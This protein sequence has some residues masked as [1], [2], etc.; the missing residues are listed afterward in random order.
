[1]KKTVFLGMLLSIG[2]YAQNSLYVNGNLHIAAG[3]TLHAEGGIDA[4]GASAVVNNLGTL[5]IKGGATGTDNINL[6]ASSTLNL[7]GTGTFTFLNQTHDTV[8]NLG[9][10]DNAK[11]IVPHSRTLF[12]DEVLTNN[13]TEGVTLEADQTSGAYAQLKFDSYAGT[14]TVKQEQ[15]L[16]YEGWHQIA[17]SVAGSLDQFGLINNA[18]GNANTFNTYVWNT[19]TGNWTQAGTS[20]T[21]IAAGTGY[22]TYVG[23]NGIAANNT[24]LDVVGVPFNNVAPTVANNTSNSQFNIAGSV[25]HNWNL[26]GNPFTCALDWNGITKTDVGSAFYIFNGTGSANITSGNYTAGQGSWVT[27]S[28]AS[29]PNATSTIAPLQAFWVQG[30]GSGN[31]S[32]GTL[33]ISTHG[34]MESSPVFYKTSS[35]QDW[36]TLVVMHD[37]DSIKQDQTTLTL[38]NGNGATDGFDIAWDAHKMANGGTIPSVYTFENNNAMAINAINFGPLHNQNKSINV[39]FKSIEQGA[40][41]SFYLND[42]YIYN[43]YTITLE[44][45][46]EQVT[47]PIQSSAYS[48]VNDTNFVDRFVLH[49]SNSLV[50]V[51]EPIAQEKLQAWLSEGRLYLKSDYD[52]QVSYELM[53]MDG[54]IIAQESTELVENS[55]VVLPLK[56]LATG[57]YVLRIQTQK[58]AQT[59][60]FKN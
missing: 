38:V 36:V 15:A 58:D 42:E 30:T 8:A 3:A 28:A 35:I 6:T 17:S 12:V 9:I 10:A 32:L 16:R 55:L 52:T 21:A 54:K 53:G 25:T 37:A 22:Y 29:P 13:A 41:F 50:S 5:S 20:A 56:K 44:D 60:K 47:H 46:K 26:V 24:K 23:T 33:N 43:S 34:T 51:E 11:V 31:P 18:A 59:L 4:T 49:F 45:K 14:G 48:F 2:A 19:G 39:S 40:P 27:G 7:S 1:M 57:I